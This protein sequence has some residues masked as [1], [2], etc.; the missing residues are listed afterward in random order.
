MEPTGS[1]TPATGP[2]SR[3]NCMQ[4]TSSHLPKKVT[5]LRIFWLNPVHIA[6]AALLNVR[7]HKTVHHF[8][9]RLQNCEEQLLAFSCLSVSME[10]LGSQREVFH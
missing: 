5:S 9:A 3:P 1:Q 7:T 8:L 6:M 10:Q 2:Y 4:S